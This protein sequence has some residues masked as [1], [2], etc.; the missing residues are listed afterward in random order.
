MTKGTVCSTNP[1]RN[2]IAIATGGREFTIV[3]GDAADFRVGDRVEWDDDSRLG[4]AT[5]RNLTRGAAVGVTALNHWVAHQ[6]LL[7]QLQT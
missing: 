5:Y 4:P 2:R 1:A 7:A 3:E 6:H